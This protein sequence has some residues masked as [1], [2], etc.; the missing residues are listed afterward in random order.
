MTSMTHVFVWSRYICEFLRASEH[1]FCLLVGF[2]HERCIQCPFFLKQ[3]KSCH[4]YKLSYK[5]AFR[6]KHVVKQRDPHFSIP[7]NIPGHLLCGF[8]SAHP[9][10]HHN[11]RENRLVFCSRIPWCSRQFQECYQ[12]SYRFPPLNSNP[13]LGHER[14]LR[15]TDL[16]SSRK[17]P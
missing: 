12:K 15:R 7:K 5:T 11:N 8:F 14:F 1:F 16:R 13:L 3:P 9:S 6:S 17:S 10:F 2:V 4:H